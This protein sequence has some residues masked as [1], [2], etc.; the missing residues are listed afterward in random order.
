MNRI[1][2]SGNVT[3]DIEV[4][5]LPA[6]SC[7]ATISLAVKF[8][9]DKEAQRNK[10]AFIEC[11]AWNEKAQFAQQYFKKGS[12]MLVEG[13]ITQDEWDDQET[14][15]KRQKTKVEVFNIEFFGGEKP[16]PQGGQQPVQHGHTDRA[17]RL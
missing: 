10:T 12:P 17:G 14:G 13:K 16:Q 6:G 7:V 1:I 11:V 4:K 5:Q 15:K 9:Y 8:G 3:R 2:I